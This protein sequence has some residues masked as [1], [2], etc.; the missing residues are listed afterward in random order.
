MVLTIF[1]TFFYVSLLCFCGVQTKKPSE[2]LV[3]VERGGINVRLNVLGLAGLRWNIKNA[4]N[5]VYG[6]SPG[7]HGA[8]WRVPAFFLLLGLAKLIAL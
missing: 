4:E 1:R 8:I 2:G 5:W 6:R 3:T 7:F